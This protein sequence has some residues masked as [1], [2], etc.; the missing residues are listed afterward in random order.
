MSQ[1]NGRM[2]DTTVMSSAISG[3]WQG[4]NVR[5]VFPPILSPLWNKE[6]ACSLFFVVASS[7]SRRRGPSVGF[8]KRR[9]VTLVV[10]FV[11]RLVPSGQPLYLFFF[12]V[13][14][15]IDDLSLI[16]S[17]LA[18]GFNRPAIRHT[19]SAVRA[20]PGSALLWI[21][22]SLHPVISH[23]RNNSECCECSWGSV[24][25]TE[26]P[27]ISTC[28]WAHVALNIY[29][30]LLAM[31]VVGLFRVAIRHKDNLKRADLL[32]PFRTEDP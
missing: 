27:E 29:S 24:P 20:N 26:F 17:F 2:T 16:D 1:D 5:H 28:C 3:H 8:V 32:I 6:K 30:Y 19:Y 22:F 15:T 18:S 9:Q 13:L 7:I 4:S 11:V 14:F 23:R 21:G 10:L 31:S 25:P 12:F